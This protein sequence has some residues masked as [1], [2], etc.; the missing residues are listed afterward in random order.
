MMQNAHVECKRA[1]QHSLMQLMS[2]IGTFKIHSRLIPPYSLHHSTGSLYSHTLNFRG[3]LLTHILSQDVRPL[4]DSQSI[5]HKSL[6]YLVPLHLLDGLF[7]YF[8]CRDLS[9]EGS[10]NRVQCQS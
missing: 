3:L 1:H 10:I 4:S 9:V 8:G 5:F 2:F 6:A 7:T